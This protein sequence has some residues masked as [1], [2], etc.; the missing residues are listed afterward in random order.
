VEFHTERLLLRRVQ[1]ADAIPL[2]E[3][4][5][6]RA[7]TRHMGPPRDFE[8]VRLRIEDEVRAGAVGQPTGWWAVVETASSR[9][10]G[11]CGLIEKDVDGHQEIELVYIF[12]SQSWG[13][14]YATEA[15][16][17]LRDY[18]LHQLG[19]QRIIALIDP[20]NHASVRVAEKIGMTF[21]SETRRP[22]GRVMRVHSLHTASGAQ[23]SHVSS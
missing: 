10:V 13:R 3:I 17:A 6:D 22:S 18:A 23:K 2:A 21:E 5:A 11:E 8:K 1:A 20:N 15:A 16:S 14:G 12:A 7:V 4:W 19:L 9:V